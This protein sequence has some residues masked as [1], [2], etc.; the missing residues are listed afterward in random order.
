MTR[1]L[2]WPVALVVAS[3]FMRGPLKALRTRVEGDLAGGKGIS[4]T[5]AGFG[6][7]F[8]AD[9]EGIWAEL[10]GETTLVVDNDQP[11]SAPEI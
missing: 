8:D 4:I 7:V 2:A 11:V 1:A 9:R 3:W 10:P 6:V 5:A